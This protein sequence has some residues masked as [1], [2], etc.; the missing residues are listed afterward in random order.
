MAKILSDEHIDSVNRILDQF[1]QEKIGLPKL[2]KLDAPKYLYMNVNELNQKNVEE[3]ND[4]IFQLNQYAL[5]IKRSINKHNSW[6]KWC[7]SKIN[8]IASANIP[9]LDKN[10][11]YNERE[12]IAKYQPDSCKIIHRYLRRIDM[13]LTR[14]DDMPAFIKNLSDSI[15]EIKFYK[16]NKERNHEHR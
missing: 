11:G 4:A 7:Y 9:R 14:L 3:L 2:A 5:F 10:L 12:L 6:R 8:E 16:L 1:E 13:E 15:R